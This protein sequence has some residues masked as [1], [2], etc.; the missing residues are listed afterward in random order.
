MPVPPFAGCEACVDVEPIGEFGHGPNASSLREFHQ[1]EH[2]SWTNAEFAELRTASAA[3][4][5]AGAR[6]GPLFTSGSAR[7]CG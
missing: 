6:T 5:I 2:A 4:A 3:L 1:G 7:R